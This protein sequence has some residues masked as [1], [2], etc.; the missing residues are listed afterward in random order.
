M[1]A[2]SFGLLGSSLGAMQSAQEASPQQMGWEKHKKDLGKPG[3]KPEEGLRRA[4][5][6]EKFVKVFTSSIVNVCVKWSQ[7]L[8]NG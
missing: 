3:E 8:C 5:R 1:G 2:A 4:E 7:V 6:E